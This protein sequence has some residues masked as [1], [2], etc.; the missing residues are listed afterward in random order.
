[1]TRKKSPSWVLE[2]P[3]AIRPDQAKRLQA[4][5]E[6]A[7]CLYNALLGEAKKRLNRMRSDPAWQ[8]ARAI[9]RTRKQER[10]AAFLRLR[11]QYGFAEYAL[12]DYAKGARCSWI[13]DHVDSTMAQTLA[14]RAYRAANRVCLGQAKQIRFRSKGRGM[15]SV[16]GKRNDTGM[17]FV[18][19]QAEEGNQGGLLW[20]EDHLLALID[21]KDVVVA[22]GL[23]QR[24]KYA[25]LVRRKA[26]SPQAQG[27]DG[28]GNRYFVQ[29]IVEGTPYQKAKNQPGTDTMGLDIGPSTLAVVPREGEAHLVEFCKELRP[30]IGK[31][32]RLQ[33][34]MQRQRRANNPHNYDERG[35]VKKHGKR[36]LHWHDSHGYQA[37]RRRHAT[38]ERKLAA[39]RKSLHGKL[40]NDLVRVGNHMQIEKT[41]FKGWQKMYGKSVGLRAPGLFVAHLT[42]IVAK[43]GG[44]LSEVATSHTKLSQ[45]CHNCKCY[46]KKPLSQR[47]HTCPCGIG[48]V[49]RDLYSA[50]LLA[51]LDPAETVPSITHD[52][53]AGVES[54][55]KAVVEVLQ[56]RANEGHSLPRSFGIPGAGARRPK[57][58]K[59]NQ[60]ELASLSGRGRPEALGLAQEPPLL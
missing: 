50:C 10:S 21:W 43:T 52:E 18:L 19:Q 5:L 30:D 20:G 41:S 24:I 33:R 26:S 40:V 25:R 2:L 38:Q 32:R 54:R 17:R 47:W 11:K 53:W 23:R 55:L 27:A 36:R 34:K 39:H 7:R 46:V 49:Q 22:Y 42:R 59:P 6:A 14:S 48:P 37:T 31:K 12:H 8:E 45:Y 35:R 9:P 29:V 13:A 3:L 57:S 58:P 44:T 51:Y 15:G 1:M 60:Q 4:H 56:Q 16:E 28:E